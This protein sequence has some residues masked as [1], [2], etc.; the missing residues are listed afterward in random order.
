MI[1]RKI[2]MPG[3]PE[4]AIGAVAS[5]NI[6]VHERRT[7]SHLAARGIDF[8]KLAK[9][10]RT[11]VKRREAIYR[12]GLPPLDL[13]N[14]T[15]VLVDDGLATGSTMLAAVRA[16]HKAGAARV[17]VVAPVASRE[18]NELV[19]AEADEVVILQTPEFLYAI[20]EWYQDFEQVNDAEVC[21]L[22]ASSRE[23]AGTS[24]GDSSERGKSSTPATERTIPS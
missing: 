9:P 20:G 23:A 3:Q 2:G 16:A 10:E 8:E 11:E 15:A 21:R 6:T 5:G 24:V 14:R 7:S 1:V 18:A 22:L 12:A 13:A 19:S 4:L 17:V